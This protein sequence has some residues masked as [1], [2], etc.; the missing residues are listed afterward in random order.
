MAFARLSGKS[1]SEFAKNMEDKIIKEEKD[2]C[3]TN[4][5]AIQQEGG[6]ILNILEV[7]QEGGE[8]FTAA[9]GPGNNTHD[10]INATEA[11]VDD[12]A[13]SSES[14]SDSGGEDFMVP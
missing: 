2:N 8:S 13:K 12:K 11:N 7:Q 1:F 6:G 3:E 9:D 5:K 14:E 10:K 4:G